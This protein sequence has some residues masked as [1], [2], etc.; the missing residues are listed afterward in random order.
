M[1][2]WFLR[3]E[4]VI[5]I[6]TTSLARV[7]NDRDLEYSETFIDSISCLQLP[8]FRSQAAIVSEKSTVFTFY[9]IE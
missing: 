3:K 5:F 4:N 1:A 9:S 7:K 6:R 8:T 2:H